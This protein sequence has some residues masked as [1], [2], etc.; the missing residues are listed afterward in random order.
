MYN[1]ILAETPNIQI[2]LSDKVKSF[3]VNF[4]QGQ[5]VKYALNDQGT[6]IVL[7][8]NTSRSNMENAVRSNIPTVGGNARTAYFITSLDSAV[9]LVLGSGV[10]EGDINM[11]ARE[12]AV[13]AV[14][15]A[16]AAEKYGKGIPVVSES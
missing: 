6:C 9:R 12:V 13:I 3:S 8:D 5:K 2:P 7:Y 15:F 14:A 1:M 11:M 10:H 16:D 4:R